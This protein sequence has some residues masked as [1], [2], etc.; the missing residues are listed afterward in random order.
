MLSSCS[1]LAEDATKATLA[2]Y[3]LK[4]KPKKGKT[5]KKGAFD[6]A[7]SR[8]RLPTCCAIKVDFR[9]CSR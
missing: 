8:T 3:K 9:S 5:G 6:E 4:Q 7:F 1:L 2:N